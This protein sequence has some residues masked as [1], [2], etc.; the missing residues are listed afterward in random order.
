[1]ADEIA[2]GDDTPAENP[3]GDVPA[4]PSPSEDPAPSAPGAGL[5]PSSSEVSDPTWPR[6][7]SG[8]MFTLAPVN[9]GNEASTGEPPPTAPLPPT[10]GSEPSRGEAPWPLPF[11]GARPP[12]ADLST[13][14]GAIAPVD[15]APTRGTEP[16]RFGGWLAVAVVAALIGGGVGAGVVLA[17]ENNNNGQNVTINEGHATPGAAVLSGNV[18]IPQLVH[19]VLP[20][21]VSIDVK[22]DGEEDQGTGMI[23]TA[24]GEV[25]TNNHV[26][27]LAEGGGTITI[28]KSGTTKARPASLIG[29]DPSHD[30]ALLQIK[31]A[32]ALPT[33][34][35]GQSNKAQ[36]GD[37]VVAIGNALGLAAGTPTVTQ[38]I[39]SALGRTV[40]AGSEISSA[41]ETLT[42]M[43]QTD[44]A[45]NPGNS[46][47][48]LIDTSGQVIAMNTAVAGNDSSGDAAQN[49][50]FAIPSATI[51]SLLPELLKGGTINTG[52]G[53]LGVEVTSMTP[54]LQQQ[55]GFTPSQGAVILS[56]TSGSPAQQG[57]LEQGDVIVGLDS[58]PITSADSLSS[59]LGKTK[60]G[61][62]VQITYYV[63]DEKHTTK[64]TLESANEEQQQQQSGQNGFGAI[65]GFGNSGSEG[66]SGGSNGGF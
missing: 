9:A 53:V 40:T 63:G 37:A 14:P 56:V 16:R 39:V 52:G 18:T 22:S 1:M 25:V 5:T 48:P 3:L 65:P 35:F 66:N 15:G 29:A 38:G 6:T 10:A 59:A 36:V 7:G 49:I 26:V 24:S 17:T 45:I 54:Q 55:Y 47:G 28:T 43:I 19:R 51:E 44:A 33:I 4:A 61:Q 30:V 64:V 20:S 8:P 11:G 50:G 60:P 31:G 41:T 34:T 23:I 2:S 62:S 32:S 58:T 42:D 27:E 12:E 13:A 21:V 46:G 57:G